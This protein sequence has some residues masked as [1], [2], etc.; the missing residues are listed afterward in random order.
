MTSKAVQQLRMI[1]IQ[2]QSLPLN[3][4]LQLSE[5]ADIDFAVGVARYMQDE[6]KVPSGRLSVSVGTPSPTGATMKIT[7]TRTKEK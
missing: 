2:M 4:E 3:A 7:L 5:G 1:A 6:L